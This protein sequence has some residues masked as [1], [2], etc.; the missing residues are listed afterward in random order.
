MGLAPEVINIL[1]H[2]VIIGMESSNLPAPLSQAIADSFLQA[3][4]KNAAEAILSIKS[5]QKKQN[6]KHNFKN[7]P[8]Q[9]EKKI[10]YGTAEKVDNQIALDALAKYQH[11]KKNS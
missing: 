5:R 4:V 11:E 9:K 3:K 1:T 2:Q 6:E 7:G 10:D 8:L